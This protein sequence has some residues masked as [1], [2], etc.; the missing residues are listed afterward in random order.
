MKKLLAT[1]VATLFAATL[2]AATAVPAS[3]GGFSIGI[4]A[5]GYDS[6]DDWDDDWD[7]DSDIVIEVPTYTEDDDDDDEEMNSDHRE[8]CENE[9]KT[10]D[11]ETNL[12]YYAVGKQ[13][14]CD[15]P[16]S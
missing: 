1:G 14:E 7:D 12:Y 9:Y 11:A 5:G 6:D 8:W 16:Y 2:L 15:S 10:Y 13:R 3:A 4:G